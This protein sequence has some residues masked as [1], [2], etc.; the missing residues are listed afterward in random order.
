MDTVKDGYLKSIKASLFDAV[1]GGTGGTSGGGSTGST[2]SAT[3]S[4]H[5]DNQWSNGFT[6]TV[7]ITNTGTVAT[8][9]WKVNWTWGG[10]Q[11]ISSGWSANVSQS[12]SAVTATSLA[13]NGAIAPGSS[14]SFGFQATFSGTNAAPT[15]TCTVT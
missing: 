2:G 14:T 5:V 8:R 15:L 4:L 6:A 13:Y 3:A 12:G 7:T 11:Q 1:G 10:S 9:S